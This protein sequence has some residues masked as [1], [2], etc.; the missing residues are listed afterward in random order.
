MYYSQ[1]MQNIQ[2]KNIPSYKISVA[3]MLDWTDRHFRYFLRLITKRALFYTEMVAVPALILGNRKKLLDY[4]PEEHPLALQVGGSDPYMMGQCAEYASDW[5]YLE[6]NINAGCPSSRV[7]AG[8]FGAVLMKTPELVG[9]CVNKMKQKTTLPV[10][11]KTRISLSDVE[12]DGFEA[13]FRFANTVKEA[14]C[15]KLIVHARKAKLNLSPKENRGD[16]LGLNHDVV[17]RLKKS[18]PDM[19][20]LINGNI[21]S[22]QDIDTH[23]ERMD[24]VM[25]GRWAYGNPYALR[26]IDARYYHDFHPIPT[27]CEI[28]EMMIP[29]LEK[30]QEALSVICPHLMG[31]F[32]GQPYSKLYRNILTARDLPALVSFIKDLRESDLRE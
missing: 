22:Y 31:L 1:N 29:Y 26:E 4:S 10:T 18:F 24:G 9:E 23:L 21:L 28:L 3:P 12:G 27:R 17:Y 32:H 13:L 19:S 8:K 30:N 20:I 25:I 7:Q 6:I 5:G 15:S 2:E 16:K 14:G 11:V